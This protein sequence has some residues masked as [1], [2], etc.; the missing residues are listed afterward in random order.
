MGYTGMRGVEKK[1]Q[2]RRVVRTKRAIRNAFV[3]LLA[4]KELEKISVKEIADR[5]DVDRKTVYNYYSGVSAIVEE[6]EN[7]FFA[8]VEAAFDEFDFTTQKGM[9]FFDAIAK[10]VE[11]NFELYELLM[12]IDGSTRLS[13][14]LVSYIK[15]KISFVIAW[16]KERASDKIDLAT[17]FVSAGILAGYKYW[18]QSERKKTLKEFSGEMGALILGGM[19]GFFFDI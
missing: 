14:K 1:T 19:N 17:E 16:P 15:K 9:E 5:A 11:E 4:E 7:E 13:A 8:T 3:N 12:R 6:L 18:F 2:D 10:L